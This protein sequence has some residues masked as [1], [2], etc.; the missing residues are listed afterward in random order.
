MAYQEIYKAAS[1]GFVHLHP[2]H[3]KE[4]L[5]MNKSACMV[6]ADYGFKVQLLPC[7]PE[8]EKQ[9]RSYWLPDVYASKNPDVRINGLLIGDIKSPGQKGYVSAAAIKRCIYT[10]SQQKVAVVIIDLREKIYTKQDIKKGIYGALQP[11]RNKSIIAVWFITTQKTLVI[12]ERK[13]LNQQQVHKLLNS[14]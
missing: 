11:E 3:G 6:L 10:A 9:L 5:I 2:L 13:M 4:E 12:I 8:N 7:I 14:I 1:G